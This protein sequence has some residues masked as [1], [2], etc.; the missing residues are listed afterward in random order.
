M[1]STKYFHPDPTMIAICSELKRK[2]HDT[3]A[4]VRNGSAEYVVKYVYSWVRWIPN[5]PNC[6]KLQGPSRHGTTDRQVTADEEAG[7]YDRIGIM[8]AG[9]GRVHVCRQKG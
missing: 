1:P 3:S 5:R 7:W 2:I 9:R 6:Y 4:F 8:A